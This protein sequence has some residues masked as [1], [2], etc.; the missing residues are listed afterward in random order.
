M[1][2]VKNTVFTILFFVFSLPVF[3]QTS[4][5][6]TVYS[7]LKNNNCNP[8]TQSL[9][10]SQNNAL[11]FN[12]TAEFPAKNALSSSIFNTK[13]NFYLIFNQ[14]DVTA[15][16]ELFL[17]L[18]EHLK[19][20]T[21]DFN[22]SLIFLYGEKQFISKDGL[23]YG[24]EVFLNYLNT[25]EDSTALLVNLDSE[26]S[27]IITAS[28][29]ITAPS[30]LIKN[31]HDVFYKNNEPCGLPLYYISQLYSYNFYKNRQLDSF[32]QTGIPTLLLNLNKEN[33][34][35]NQKASILID[36]LEVFSRTHE[37]TWDQHFLLFRFLGRY[38]RLSES[39]TV[40]IIIFLLLTFLLFIALLGFININL[41]K[42]A[43]EKIRKIW[44]VVP[45]TF[46]IVVLSLFIGKGVFLLLRKFSAGAGRL[47]LMFGLELF[48]TFLLTTIYFIIQIMFNKQFK[49]RSI[50]FVIVIT[51]VINQVIFLFFD[52]SL[53]P[54]FMFLCI[55]SV[56]AL[57]VKNN[58]T[59]IIL[60]LLM[61]LPIAIY[62]HSLTTIYNINLLFNY[63]YNNN[64]SVIFIALVIY[65]IF[66]LYF[67]I[68]FAF[69]EYFNKRKM[70]FIG[71]GVTLSIALIF[72]LLIGVI[73]TKNVNN[74]LINKEIS[75]P[76]NPDNTN[77]ISIS[78]EDK[79]VFSDKIRTLS[80]DFGKPCH[81]CDIRL[82][83]KIGTPVLY[84]ADDYETLSNNEAIF[85]VPNDPPS[86][87]K[88]SYGT[89]D[90]PQ[91]ITVTAIYADS[92]KEEFS[93]TT[94]SITIN[95]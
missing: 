54:V 68:L 62:A 48:F 40:R 76:I 95:K 78:Y 22:V 30:W 32:F 84:S 49:P 19:T 87:L 36:S 71:G 74:S 2:S 37:R 70:L 93:L 33:H 61:V 90:L 6:N 12:V 39:N 7:F 92:N 9:V 67:R 34:N 5:S 23:I 66:L 59:H 77:S 26:T 69:E 15:N 57:K 51:I 58:I 13:R 28:N 94:K 65:P 47:Y 11:P 86:K 52:I 63:L 41:Q 3:S 4:L 31:E 29:G 53:F 85:L 44:Y 35:Y 25:N 50:D 91:T 81:E 64:F 88:F 18:F 82:H 10:S 55:V 45:I 73:R 72:I 80:I 83:S 20:S 1:K 21:Y 75:Y 43:W 42:E 46:A 14:E 60:L 17:P 89:E 27:Q 38:L 8:K 56:I 24:S 79:Q 16:Y